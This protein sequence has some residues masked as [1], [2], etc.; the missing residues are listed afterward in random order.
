MATLLLLLLL[1]F[2]NAAA[3]RPHT[4]PLGDYI[5]RITGEEYTVC[6]ACRNE[7]RN[8]RRLEEIEEHIRRAEEELERAMGSHGIFNLAH[9]SDNSESICPRLS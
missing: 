3:P 2:D 4:K 7:V 6:E 9:H 8:I 5:D 1:F